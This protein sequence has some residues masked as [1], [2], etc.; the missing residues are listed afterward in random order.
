MQRLPKR[1]HAR[2]RLRVGFGNRHQDADPARASLRMRAPSAQRCRAG[3]DRENLPPPHS[4]TWPGRLHG[5]I[6]PRAA[7]PITLSSARAPAAL[8]RGGRFAKRVSGTSRPH[9]IATSSGPSAWTTRSHFQTLGRISGHGR[10][11]KGRGSRRPSAV[12]CWGKCWG[13]A[14]AARK[15]RRRCNRLAEV[16]GGA[17]GIRTPDLCSAIAA[18]SHLSYSPG[19]GAG[20]V[21]P[22]PSPVNRRAR[23]AGAVRLPP[24]CR[25]RRLV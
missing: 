23:S 10:Q 16:H 21:G 2:P 24:P 12:A 5:G 13:M 1:H 3:K 19:Q 11:G 4:I 25:R 7:T 18:L 14:E 22:A 15:I 6:I 20:L 8:Q 9:R 17:E